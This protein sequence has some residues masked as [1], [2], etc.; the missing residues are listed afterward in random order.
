MGLIRKTTMNEFCPLIGKNVSVQVEYRGMNLAGNQGTH[1]TKMQPSCPYMTKCGIE[2]G[3]DCLI[4]QKA[5]EDVH[6]S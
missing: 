2:T 6:L 4:Y 5:P 1:L 3:L